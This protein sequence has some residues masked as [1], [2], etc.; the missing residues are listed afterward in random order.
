MVTQPLPGRFPHQQKSIAAYLAQTH[1]ARELIIVVDPPSQTKPALL[2]THCAGLNRA[3]IKLVLAPGPA[4]LGRL[5]NI[6]KNAATGDIICQWDDDDFHHPTRLATQL[7]TL[8]ATD[9]EAVFLQDVL[10]YVPARNA[11][12]WTNWRATPAGGHPGTIMAR[13]AAAIA[14]PETGEAA[15][16]GEDLAVALALRERG[17]ICHLAGAA[18]LFVYVSHGAN[19][20]SARH[21]EMLIETLAISR[22]LLRRRAPALRENLAAFALPPET[23]L[24]GANGM[25]CLL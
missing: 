3:D 1:E 9:S 17:R 14:Y 13:R 22:A 18:H 25:A 21:H 11:L 8:Q 12:Y 5:R 2:A 16:R 23:A 19:T 20:W 7:A 24:H 15:A 10:Q 6:A 4:S